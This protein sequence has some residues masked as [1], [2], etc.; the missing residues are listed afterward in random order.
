MKDFS[1]SI[2]NN[3]VI[4]SCIKICIK[5]CYKRNTLKEAKI[6]CD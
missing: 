4:S 6:L 1:A 5:I 2:E 3:L